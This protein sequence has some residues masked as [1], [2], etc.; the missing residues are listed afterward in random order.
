MVKNIKTNQTNLLK[1]V[2]DLYCQ[3]PTM[4]GNVLLFP[5][6]HV[7]LCDF[8]CVATKNLHLSIKKN[9]DK[10]KYLYCYVN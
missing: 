6:L 4:V 2:W 10:T 3:F 7:C 1:V 8:S 5:L 9:K